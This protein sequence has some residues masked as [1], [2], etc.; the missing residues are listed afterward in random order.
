MSVILHATDETLRVQP[1]LAARLLGFTGSFK[2][3]CASVA[4]AEFYPRGYRLGIHFRLGLDA[5]FCRIGRFRVDD[6]QMYVNIRSRRPTLLLHLK[7]KVKGFDAVC[8]S[9]KDLSAV[10]AALKEY[11]VAARED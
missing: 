10:L 3:P 2:F 1:N 9:G 6:K 5:G 7:T 8:V 11:G 4:S